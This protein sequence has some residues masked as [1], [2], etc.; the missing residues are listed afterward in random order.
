VSEMTRAEATIRPG[1]DG[2]VVA[3]VNRTEAELRL[4]HA[5]HEV[6]AVNRVGRSAPDW[7]TLTT[8]WFA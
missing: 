5:H 2:Q 7:L 1:H 8:R 4:A 3:V 6:V